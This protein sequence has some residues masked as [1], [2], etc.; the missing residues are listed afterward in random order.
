MHKAIFLDLNGV[1][2]NSEPL[3][4]RFETAYGVPIAVFLPVLKQS[5]GIVRKPG[6]PALY[7]LWEQ[8]LKEWGVELT[9]AAFLDFWF[10]GETL[11]KEVLNYVTEL[12]QK[13][14]HT[15][16]VSNNFKERT[17][18][19][20]ERF[21]ELFTSV[22]KVYFSCE[23]GFIKPDPAALAWALK[24]HSLLPAEVLYFDDSEENIAMAQSLGISAQLWVDVKTAKLLIDNTFAG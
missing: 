2:V 6:A 21:T 8:H 5:M 24:E 19:Y 7:S 23:T 15:L 4:A 9:E 18:F 16:V 22:A 11:N 3:S 14:V 20:R 1:L 12:K 10:S 17:Q 13:G